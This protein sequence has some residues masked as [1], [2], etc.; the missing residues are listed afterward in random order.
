MGSPNFAAKNR[1]KKNPRYISTM[2]YILRSCRFCSHIEYL[3]LV[4]LSYVKVL[5]LVG[6]DGSL[7]TIVISSTPQ[8]TLM[9]T[10][11]DIC[12]INLAQLGTQIN[13]LFD[14]DHRVIGALDNCGWLD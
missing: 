12:Q 2:N 8:I 3:L 11:S 7:C 6:L 9:G 4:L 1:G 13:W 5:L 14:V 10:L